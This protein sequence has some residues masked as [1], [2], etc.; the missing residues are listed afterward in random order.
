MMAKWDGRERAVKLLELN[1]NT[2][3]EFVYSHLLLCLVAHSVEWYDS[4]TVKQDVLASLFL[5]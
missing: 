4:S 1:S 3:N 2:Q 5:E